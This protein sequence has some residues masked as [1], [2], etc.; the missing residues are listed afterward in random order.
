ME[1]M[2]VTRTLTWLRLSTVTKFSSGWVT[3]RQATLRVW[4]HVLILP[5]RGKPSPPQCSDDLDCSESLIRMSSIGHK[6]V[7]S[8]QHTFF[9]V[10]YDEF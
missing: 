1:Q 8:L 5:L 2:P 4:G 9:Q 7:M 10:I 6:E 3:A